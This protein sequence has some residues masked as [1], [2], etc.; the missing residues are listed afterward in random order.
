VSADE[1]FGLYPNLAT[2]VEEELPSD[3]RAAEREFAAAP[4]I[5]SR[6]QHLG[7]ADEAIAPVRP[8]VHRA[9]KIRLASLT[10]RAQ[11][12][13]A[14]EIAT[15]L[16]GRL[17]T[18]ANLR[19][20]GSIVATI[21]A[22]LAGILALVLDQAQLQAMAAFVAML[23]GLTAAFADRLQV[24]VGG[25]AVVT[26]EE[27]SKLV[28]ERGKL[29]VLQSKLERDKVL[30][31]SDPELEAMFGELDRINIYLLVLKMA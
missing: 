24:A 12:K 23:G 31:L 16:R 5:F 22:G 7:G 13:R 9:A 18:V 8:A 3:Y 27:Y 29:A 1:L 6:R 20:A 19:F 4:E 28:D 25:R 21:G 26:T 17:R 2:V 14:D 30:P 11:V 15:G 10:V